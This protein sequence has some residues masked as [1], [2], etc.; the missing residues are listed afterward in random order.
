M[1]L[2]TGKS[3]VMFTARYTVATLIEAT[4]SIVKLETRIWL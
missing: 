3:K 2:S 4:I 1:N